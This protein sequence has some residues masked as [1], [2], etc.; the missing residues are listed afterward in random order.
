MSCFLVEQGIDMLIAL[1][2]ALSLSLLSGQETNQE[3]GI[4]RPPAGINFLA[5]GGEENPV[6]FVPGSYDLD[7]FTFTPWRNILIRSEDMPDLLEHTPFDKRRAY[8]PYGVRI[9]PESID[10]PLKLLQTVSKFD[11]RK[12]Y[13]IGLHIYYQNIFVQ[14][15]GVAFTEQAVRAVGAPQVVELSEEDVERTIAI[16]TPPQ[17]LE[18]VLQF[19]AGQEADSLPPFVPVGLEVSLKAHRSLGGE[20]L[21]RRLKAIAAERK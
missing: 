10:P 5:I 18:T 11:G 19:L 2:A 9:N 13:H 14:F 15:R 12:Y 1:L 17:Y 20:S 8:N 6:A 21:H 4:A 3:M 7:S 16:D